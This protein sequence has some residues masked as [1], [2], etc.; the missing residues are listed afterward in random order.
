MFWR[1]VG[2]RVFGM[3]SVWVFHVFLCFCV[4][5]ICNQGDK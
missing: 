1:L 3:A 2:H 5:R 4:S